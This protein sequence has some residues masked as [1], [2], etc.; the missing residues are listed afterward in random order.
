MSKTKT[1]IIVPSCH[2]WTQG[3]N[4]PRPVG[5]QTLHFPSLQARDGAQ[6]GILCSG[7]QTGV[8]FVLATIGPQGTGLLLK[9]GR[10]SSSTKRFYL[11]AALT[12]SS[13]EP[14][15]KVVI[16]FTVSK[17]PNNHLKSYCWDIYHYLTFWIIFV[18]KYKLLRASQ[19]VLVVKNSPVNAEEIKDGSLIPG[20]ERSSGEGNVS[21]FQ[22][23]CIENPHG[24]R[25]H[26]VAKWG[27][28]L[29]PLI[30]HT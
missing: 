27:T 17:I 7:V 3:K 1:C 5:E 20:L 13:K 28:W 19:V 21:P 2:V 29:K 18:P 24:Q 23:S 22:Y 15:V 12:K 6:D 26:R 14:L 30:T 10:N 25:T 9:T 16:I 8:S 11:V 4:I